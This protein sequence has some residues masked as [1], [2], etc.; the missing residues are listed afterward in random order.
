MLRDTCGVLA[1]QVHRARKKA[2]G[3]E[4]AIK[5]IDKSVLKGTDVKMLASECAVLKRESAEQRASHFAAMKKHV[6]EHEGATRELKL[7]LLS[8]EHEARGVN[9]DK[10]ADGD[11]G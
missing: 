8:V 3:E 6:A 9:T 1:A 11:G 7:R 5:S 2:G 10:G 4:V